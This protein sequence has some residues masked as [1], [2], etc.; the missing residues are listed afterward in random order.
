M[1]VD[2][3]V[4]DR[5]IG[6]QWLERSKPEDLVQDLVHN[7]PPLSGGHRYRPGGEQ[8]GGGGWDRGGGRLA[9]QG[10]QRLEIE[11]VDYGPVE[12]GLEVL[13]G[14]AGIEVDL[15]LHRYTS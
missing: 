3:D 7:L 8:I 5:F 6:E 13:I 11:P 1:R 4:G 12:P 15:R 2:Q 14:R 10:L 9:V